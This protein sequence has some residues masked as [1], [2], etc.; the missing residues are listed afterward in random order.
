M[1]AMRE[2]ILN[3]LREDGNLPPLPRVLLGLQKLI[4]D[5][6][7]DAADI[8]R[9]IK[10]DSVLTGKLITLSNSVFFG[11]GRDRADDL[12]GAIA[13]LGL[14]MVLDLCYS[15]ELPKA[16]KNPKGFDQVQFWQ[17]SLA[18]GYLSR[19]LAHKLIKEQDALNVSFMAGLM[20]DTGILVFDYLIPDEFYDFLLTKDIGSSDQ[21]L[22]SLEKFVFGIDHPEL[23]AA[24]LQKWWH[25]PPLVAE[26]VK[27]HHE[28]LAETGGEIGLI[29]VVNAAN[30][31]ADAYGISHPIATRYKD[32]P[33][34]AFLEGAGI[35]KTELDEFIEQTKIGLLAF[36]NLFD[37]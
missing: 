19:M 20:H 36:D 6:G 25:V 24:F 10:A 3:S 15:L 32:D 23:G 17:H 14:K 31:L 22:N 12:E 34:E 5:P 11:G 9:L 26:A 13:R 27:A 16:F 28:D 21:P 35:S 7:C 29:H 37:S 4:N 2:K 33:A 18:V 1:D 8:H 30:K